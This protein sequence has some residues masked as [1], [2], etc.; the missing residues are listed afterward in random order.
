MTN[1]NIMMPSFNGEIEPDHLFKGAELQLKLREVALEIEDHDAAM[2]YYRTAQ[3][4]AQIINM[5][6]QAAILASPLSDIFKQLPTIMPELVALGISDAQLRLDFKEAEDAEIIEMVA[7]TVAHK[8]VLKSK[9]KSP[10]TRVRINNYKQR[11]ADI[12]EKTKMKGVDLF[13]LNKKKEKAVRLK[14]ASGKQLTEEEQTILFAK[15]VRETLLEMINNGGRKEAVDYIVNFLFRH[16]HYTEEDAHLLI[17][18]LKGHYKVEEPKQIPTIQ[19]TK[20]E[21]LPTDK[22]LFVRFKTVKKNGEVEKEV[23]QGSLARFNEEVQGMMS[24]DGNRICDPGDILKY[25]VAN[26]Y[27]VIRIQDILDNI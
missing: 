20:I 7:G 19:F 9:I 22:W 21:D 14:Q 10:K 2:L 15:G 3:A 26:K 18:G 13:A 16:D 1:K 23:V 17:E 5:V 11:I 4:Y 24:P 27:E 8:E 25:R 6:A 12:M